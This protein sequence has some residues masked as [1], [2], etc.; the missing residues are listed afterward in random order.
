M[1][2]Q[3]D[4][5]EQT[6]IRIG[7]VTYF[8]ARPLTFSLAEL[9]PRMEII[10]DLPSRLADSLA[11]G[12]LDVALVPSIEYFRNKGYTIVSDACVACDG[13]VRSVKL[14]GRVPVERIETLAL[15]EGSRTSA[16][17]TQIFLRE[18]YGLQPQI[19]LLPIGA[20]IEDTAADAV[21]LMGDRGMAPPNGRFDFV[22]DMGR[23][24][25]QW[26]GLPFVFAMWIARPGVDLRAAE[27]VLTAA[28]DDGAA[29]LAEIARL[30][31]AD[32]GLPEE[33]CLAYLR[34]HLDFHL[35]PR[36]QE[37]LQLFYDLA[38]RHQLAPA[39]VELVFYDQ[40]VAG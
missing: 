18:Q 13:P 7:A 24:W 35:G 15:D 37:G 36:Q 28:R 26:A 10:I 31:A 29:R 40:Q 27:R 12:R 3:N 21:M 19:E 4:F 11:A 1:S 14:F 9:A 8:N 16:A 39:G 34:D 32:L 20:G 33:E 23:Q 22:W 38:T 6:A 2:E 30:E 17:M 5:G 25:S